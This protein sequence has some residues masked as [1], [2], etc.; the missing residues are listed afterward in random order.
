MSAGGV[1]FLW[2]SLSLGFYPVYSNL[3]YMESSFPAV[4]C[5]LEKLMIAGRESNGGK[6]GA[7][8]EFSISIF[9]LL[10]PEYHYALRLSP[11][12]AVTNKNMWGDGD[13]SLWSLFSMEIYRHLKNWKLD[14]IQCVCHCAKHFTW[15]ISFNPHSNF[16][17]R[18]YC[19]PYFT[20][21]WLDRG[22]S[23]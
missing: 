19:Y 18:Y 12:I 21:K 7:C 16:R 1:T 22:H 23:L 20:N 3:A 15:I 6:W 13:F 5:C 9:S 11:C 14:H 4:I 10:P 2:V 17:G 8:L